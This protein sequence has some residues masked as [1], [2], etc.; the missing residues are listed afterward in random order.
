MTSIKHYL[1]FNDFTREEYDYVFQRAK[2]IKDKFK[3]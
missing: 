3:R 1:Q 2:W